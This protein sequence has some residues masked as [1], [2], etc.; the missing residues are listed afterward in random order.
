MEEKK[1]FSDSTKKSLT[2]YNPFSKKN[3]TKERVDALDKLEKIGVTVILP[4]K[5]TISLDWVK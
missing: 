2:E 3:D 1:K 4:E 5:K